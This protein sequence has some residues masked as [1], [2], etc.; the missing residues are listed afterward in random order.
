MEIELISN[1][2]ILVTQSTWE[3]FTKDCDKRKK[4]KNYK[5]IKEHPWFPQAWALFQ[6][7]VLTTL[8]KEY[9][10]VLTCKTFSLTQKCFV[11][12]EKV[13]LVW[14]WQVYTTV[15]Y[16][17]MG[18]HFLQVTRTISKKM[19]RFHSDKFTSQA[20]TPLL[21]SYIVILFPMRRQVQNTD[22][23]SQVIV[24][25]IQKVSQTLV[26]AN[27]RPKN[28]CLRLAWLSNFMLRLHSM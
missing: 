23:R 6:C 15:V 28:F 4:N 10:F 21:F 2:N 26:K 13:W 3:I 19:K 25:P 5:K 7:N 22:H 17:K 12:T 14:S 1:Q 8:F 11:K 9:N 16:G 20:I 24:S 18:G 27:L